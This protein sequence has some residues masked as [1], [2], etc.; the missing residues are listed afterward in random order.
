[1]NMTVF[2]DVALSDLVEVYQCFRGACC[3]HHQGNDGGINIIYHEHNF[4]FSA[5]WNFFTS[6]GKG[7][8]D[9]TEA[10]LKRVAAKASL[11]KVYNNQIQTPHELFNYCSSDIHNITLFYVQE[12]QIL[13]CKKE[14]ADKFDMALSIT[15]T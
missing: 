2:W 3:R 4:G 13:N 8:A 10:T 6:H 1:M 7:P 9:G 12:E 15:G 14:L 5:E 11:Q